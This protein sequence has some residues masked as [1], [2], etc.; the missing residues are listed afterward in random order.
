MASPLTSGTTS[1]TSGSIRKCD[2]LSM[3]TAPAAAARGACFSETAAPGEKRAMSMPAK[4]NVASDCTF[5]GVSSPKE[6]SRP[7]EVSEARATTSSA[8]NARSARICSISWPTAPVAPTMAMRYPMVFSVQIYSEGNRIRY[9]RNALF[10]R[11]PHALRGKLVE[12]AQQGFAHD[13]GR[14]PGH[15]RLHDVGRAQATVKNMADRRFDGVGFT[16]QVEGI[17]Q[18]HG[19]A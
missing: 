13:R 4:S 1:G 15:A 6:T 17:P 7:L 16:L 5:K 8:G 11:A 9:A 14:D 19:K 12:F 18:Q 2:V 10:S 3:T